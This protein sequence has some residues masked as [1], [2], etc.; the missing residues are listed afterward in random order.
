MARIRNDLILS[1]EGYKV[2]DVITRA[3]E[4]YVEM[5]LSDKDMEADWDDQIECEEDAYVADTLLSKVHAAVV[6]HEAIKEAM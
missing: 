1:L 5:R 2:V 6:S 3:L 4:L